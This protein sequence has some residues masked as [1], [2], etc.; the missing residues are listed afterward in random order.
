M[1]VVKRFLKPSLTKQEFK[2]ECDINNILRRYKKTMKM[3]FLSQYQGY[4]DG[5]FGDVSFATDY[6]SSLAMIDEARGVFEAMP[7]TLRARF[8][9]DPM[10]LV[11]FLGNT[12]NRQEAEQLGLIKKT[13]S[14]S[15]V[16]KP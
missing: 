15:E 8:N 5:R 14:V 12:A 10:Q 7:A 13:E 2:A 11:I 1:K 3:D 16:P 9:N 6:Q 4:L